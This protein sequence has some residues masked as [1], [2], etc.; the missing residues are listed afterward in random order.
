MDAQGPDC[1]AE[2]VVRRGDHC[3]ALGGALQEDRCAVR[4]ASLNC[5]KNGEGPALSLNLSPAVG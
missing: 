5:R 1:V 4:M 2:E 3:A